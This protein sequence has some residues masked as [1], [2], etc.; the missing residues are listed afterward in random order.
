MINILLATGLYPPESGGPATYAKLL[1]ERMPAFGFEVTVLPFRAVRHLPKIFRHA[2]YFLKCLGKARGVNI[3]LAQD[4]VS[5]GFPAALAAKLTGKKFVLRVPGDYVWEQA[6]QRYGVV[7]ELDEFQTKSY[8]LRVGLLRAI[9]KFVARSANVVIVPSGYMQKIVGG[10]GVVPMLVYNGI[11]IPVPYELPKERP[12][13][14]FIVSFGRQVPWK[15]FDA[16]RRVVAREPRWQLKIFD[17]LPRVQAMGWVKVASVYVNNSTY[18]GLSHQLLEAMALGT[19]IVA[20]SVGGNPELVQDG[21]L[22]IPAKDDEALYQALKKI[23]DDQA[24]TQER[25]RR[26]EERVQEFAIPTTLQ[27]LAELLKTI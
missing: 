6:R 3:I 8:G 18:E 27:K 7:D 25:A 2:A 19:P 23:E 9:Q 21:G 14:F 1:E 12:E 26:A 15:G 24:G 10:W 13:G 5:V 11:D 17:N 22:L 4:T 20:T 16:L